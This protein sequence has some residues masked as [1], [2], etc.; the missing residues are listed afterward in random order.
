MNQ[1]RRGVSLIELT[2]VVAVF[3]VLAAALTPVVSTTIARSKVS[4]ARIDACAIR[5][6]V[7][8]MLDDTNAL[9]VVADGS[10][11]RGCQDRCNLI[12]SDGDIPKLGPDGDAQ[13]TQPVDFHN[14]DFM[15]YHLTQNRP[16]NDPDNAYRDW[17]GAYLAGPIGPD[18]WGNRYMVNV[19]YIVPGERYDVVVISAGPDEE[20]DSAFKLDGFVPGDDDIICLVTSGTAFEARD[21]SDDRH[22]KRGRHSGKS[23]DD[24]DRPRP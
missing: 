4:R 11:D 6:A 21:K 2:V 24:H 5:D 17:N 3:A 19:R 20:I 23:R 13:W 12:V 22:D 1:S 9:G 16:G 7:L 10:V 15:E 8:N 18:P 14:V